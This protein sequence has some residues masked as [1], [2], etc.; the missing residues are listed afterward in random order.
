MKCLLRAPVS[1]SKC[2][3]NACSF[4]PRLA[5]RASGRDV[6]RYVKGSGK[7][8]CRIVTRARSAAAATPVAKALL[9][10]YS[11]WQ[12]RRRTPRQTDAPHNLF[13]SCGVASFQD[14]RFA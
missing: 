11:T 1:P 8:A 9:E 5:V 3:P 7:L 12:L 2:R 13:N 4:A 10:P 14:Q 6:D